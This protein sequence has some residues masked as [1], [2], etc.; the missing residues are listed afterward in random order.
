MRGRG[1]ANLI[2]SSLLLFSLG[3]GAADHYTAR[4]NYTLYCQGCHLADG[5][6]TPAKVPALK[7][8]VGRFL[9]VKGGREYLV[10]VPGTSQSPLTDAEVA[11]VLNWIL[12]N[13]SAAQLPADFIPF[14]AAEVAR[15]RR[16]PLTNAA[17]VRAG[18]LRSLALKHRGR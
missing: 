2:A 13:F 3:A 6:G 5:A 7:N 11:A 15:Y 17:R 8:E 1:T 18:L 14:S 10:R 16:E 12:H 9:G 4:V